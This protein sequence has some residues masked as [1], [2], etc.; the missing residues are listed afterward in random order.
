MDAELTLEKAVN[1]ARQSAAFKKQ[2]SVVRTQINNDDSK[3]DAIKKKNF[4]FTKKTKKKQSQIQVQLA[5]RRSVDKNLARGVADAEQF[6]SI[7][8]EIAEQHSLFAEAVALKVIG[9]NFVSRGKTFM[10]SKR[11]ITAMRTLTWEPSKRSR[12]RA[13]GIYH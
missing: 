9:K 13:H 6:L 11:T 4:K 3:L 10:N 12:V 8:G 7:Q 5:N 2:Q 1:Q